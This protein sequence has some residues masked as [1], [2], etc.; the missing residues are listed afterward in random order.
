[1]SQ[2]PLG[3][4][5]IHFSTNDPNAYLELGHFAGEESRSSSNFED[6]FPVALSGKTDISASATTSPFFSTT[7]SQIPAGSLVAISIRHRSA[8]GSADALV[9]LNGSKLDAI[10]GRSLRGSSGYEVMN[11]FLVDE[12]RIF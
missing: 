9:S 7:S 6:Y 11:Y 8:N 3:Q 2:F 12:G 4:A 5:T 1:M 10:C